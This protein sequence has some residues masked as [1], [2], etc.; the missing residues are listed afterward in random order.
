M[1][2]SEVTRLLAAARECNTLEGY[3]GECGGSLPDDSYYEDDDASK[4]VEVLTVLYE[5]R[6]GININTL[7]R[8]YGGSVAD[9]YREYG[10]PRRTMQNWLTETN[11][12]SDPPQYLMRLILADLI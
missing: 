6:D 11:N 8:L 3:I 9:F 2:L 1:K 12:H 5:C 7:L 10:I 4:A